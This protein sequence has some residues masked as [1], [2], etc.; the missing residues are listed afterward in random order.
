MCGC[1]SLDE[2][3][4]AETVLRLQGSQ[5]GCQAAKM[6][7]ASL[8]RSQQVSGCGAE[9]VWWQFFF[10]FCTFIF[11]FAFFFFLFFIFIYL[12]IYL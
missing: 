4:A 7:F 5:Q 11:L 2:C 6:N 3:G 8:Q 9:I 12:F 1:K 10:S